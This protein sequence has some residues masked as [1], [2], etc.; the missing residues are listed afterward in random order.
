MDSMHMQLSKVH[1]ELTT[2]DNC[3]LLTPFGSQW[4]RRWWRWYETLTINKTSNEQGLRKTWGSFKFFVCFW[5]SVTVLRI[6]PVTIWRDERNNNLHSTKKQVQLFIY[7]C[8]NYLSFI[9]Y[10]LII[11]LSF[12]LSPVVIRVRLSFTHML[13]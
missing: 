5:Q 10:F 3:I 13:E 7:S 11:F 8:K 1:V 6:G 4:R 12:F 9:L 2:R